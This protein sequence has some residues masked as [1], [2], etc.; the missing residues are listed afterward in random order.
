MRIQRARAPHSRSDVSM[1]GDAPGTALVGVT[2]TP[3]RRVADV[4]TVGR[5]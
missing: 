3:H 2:V 4:S 5:K 1:G